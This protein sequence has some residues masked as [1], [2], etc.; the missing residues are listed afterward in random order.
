MN[1]VPVETIALNEPKMSSSIV[2]LTSALRKVQASL[3]PALKDSTNPF[4][5]SKYADLQSVWESIRGPLND[6]GFAVIQLTGGNGTTLSVTT[7]LSH[8]SGEWISGITTMT[9]AKND[10]QGAGS[11][12]SY[13]RR[14]A[15]SAMLCTYASDDD[16]NEASKPAPKVVATTNVKF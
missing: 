9:P 16:A 7:I 12:Y 1:T 11:C 10:P 5:K 3:T 6:N 15:L 14:Y 2:N 4:F 13:A 8:V